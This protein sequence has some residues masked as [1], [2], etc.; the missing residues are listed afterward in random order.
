MASAR[1]LA[2]LVTTAGNISSGA[3]DALG[4]DE[5][6]GLEVVP[7]VLELLAESIATHTS[8]PSEELE[9]ITSYLEALI[10]RY[11]TVR[12]SMDALGH[13][14]RRHTLISMEKTAAWLEVMSVTPTAIEPTLRRHAALTIIV[15]KWLKAQGLEVEAQLAAFQD[16][17]DSPIVAQGA[18]TTAP[19]TI[20]SGSAPKPEAPSTPEPPLVVVEPL[21]PVCAAAPNIEAKPVHHEDG[22]TDFDIVLGALVDGKYFGEEAGD[23]AWN[24]R[25]E[26]AISQLQSSTDPAGRAAAAIIARDFAAAD[27]FLG[28][29]GPSTDSVLKLTLKADRLFFDRKF[30]EA[31]MLYRQADHERTSVSTR[32]NLAVALGRSTRGNHDENL[33]EAIDLLED[34]ASLLPEGSSEWARVRTALGLAWMHAPTGS[35]EHRC[36]EAAACFESA[37]AA[38]SRESDPGWWAEAQLQLGIVWVDMPSGDRVANITRAMEHLEQALMIWTLENEPRRWAVVKNHLGH[39]WERFPKGSRDDNLGR[40]IACYNEALA[41]RSKESSPVSWARVQNNLGNAWIQYQSTSPEHHANVERAITCHTA[42]LEVWSRL[43]RRSEW[44]ATQNNL[45]NAWALLPAEGADRERNLRRAIACYKAALEVRTRSMAPHDWAATQNNLGTAL[46]H[47]P[48]GKKDANLSEAID[49]FRKALEVRTRDSSAMDWA[50]TQA[51]LGQAW[52]KMTEGDRRENLSEAVEHFESALE[53]FTIAAHPHQHQLTR[54]R[55]EEVRDRL[56]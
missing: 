3:I 50:R 2:K 54:S 17:L 11:G 45:G 6:K 4:N 32:M 55:L 39:A 41:A 46:M 36:R 38:L 27:T 43:N 15:G 24:M 40:A 52:S 53:V 23:L 48:P 47:L 12:R 10:S 26:A 29:L 44:A 28:T 35:K 31:V 7:H 34:A 49:C 56:M 30:D 33:K 20:A 19:V 5:H 21:S 8:P 22:R 14:R 18:E 1:L 37:A 25:V 13:G 16:W 42:A 9:Q 51:N